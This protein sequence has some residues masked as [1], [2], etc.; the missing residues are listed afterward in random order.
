MGVG[1][2]DC[3][4]G[5]GARAGLP[6]RGFDEDLM[7]GS[8]TWWQLARCPFGNRV[9]FFG[10]GRGGGDAG[11]GRDVVEVACDFHTPVVCYGVVSRKGTPHPSPPA[12]QGSPLLRRVVWFVPMQVWLWLAPYLTCCDCCHRRGFSSAVGD[13]RS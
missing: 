2:P 3:F 9:G 5:A 6:G 12:P 7:R 10:G 1:P 4:L 8:P 13:W 11:W